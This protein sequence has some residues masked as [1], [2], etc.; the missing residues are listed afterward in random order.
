MQNTLLQNMATWHIEHFKLKELE[1]CQVR[2]GL[3]DLPPSV[4][5]GHKTFTW[6]VCSVYPEE[7]STF[8]SE[9]KEMPRKIWSNRHCCFPQFTTLSSYPLVLYFFM[10]FHSSSAVGWTIYVGLHVLTKALCHIKLLLNRFVFFSLANLS[11]NSLIYR[12]LTRKPE[13]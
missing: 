10:T 5:V 11:F 4:E 6:E 3:S 7:R 12:A 2:E 8:T 9:D 13:R 1:K